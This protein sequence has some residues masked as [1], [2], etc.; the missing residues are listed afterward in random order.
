MSR[1]ITLSVLPSLLVE[2]LLSGEVEIPGV[3]LHASLAKNMDDNARRMTRLEFDVGETSLATYL[4]GREQG[5]R[6]IA[7]P[8]FTSNRR[9]PHGTYRLSRHAG[10]RDLSELR[11]RTIAATQYW[12]A[13]SVWQREFLSS[14][15]GLRPEDT[16]WITFQP[17]RMEGLEVPA[18]LDHR[19]DESGRSA[20]DLAEAGLIHLTLT[21]GAAAWRSEQPGESQPSFGPAFPDVAAAEREYYRRTGLYPMHHV[22]AMR[23]ELA[24]QEPWLVEAVAGAFLRAKEI[25]QAPEERK[26]SPA[27][28]AGQTTPELGELFGDAWPYGI[29][30]NRATLEAFLDTSHEQGLVGRRH[31]IDEIFAPGLP[32]AL[33]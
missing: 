21:P 32:E 3:T 15:Y 16:S 33:Q 5:V 29:G 27:P 4:R 26:S 18:G 10:I 14:E 13:S 7:L 2:P 25:A 12:T 11:G 20:N 23:E 31:T 22:M 17:E 6:A 24:M 30:P 8:I 9:L 19:L 1:E 28:K